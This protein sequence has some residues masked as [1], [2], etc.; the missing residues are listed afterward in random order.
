MFL[1]LISTEYSTKCR[2]GTSISV[3]AV[4]DDKEYMVCANKIAW[5]DDAVAQ[6]PQKRTPLDQ[7][8]LPSLYKLTK[9]RPQIDLFTYGKTD[10]NTTSSRSGTVDLLASIDAV[11]NTVEGEI[12]NKE[13]SCKGTQQRSR[14]FGSIN[15]RRI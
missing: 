15:C 1:S 4:E 14:F 9:S 13:N 8:T 7:N 12:K 11:F 2:E 5:I 10:T 6:S 3:N